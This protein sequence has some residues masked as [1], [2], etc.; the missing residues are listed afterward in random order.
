MRKKIEE[1]LNAQKIE[2]DELNRLIRNYGKDGD[3]RKTKRYL[4]D[5]LKTFS[6][7]FNVIGG[8]NQKIIPLYDHS[9]HANQPYFKEKT[10]A[11]IKGSYEAAKTD[12]LERLKVLDEEEV[13]ASEQSLNLIDDDNGKSPSATTTAQT[14]DDSTATTSSNETADKTNGGAQIEDS[15]L[16]MSFAQEIASSGTDMLDIQYNDL[17]ELIAGANDINENS[18][19]GQVTTY[20]QMLND[21]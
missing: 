12:I 4:E 20:V 6:E 10:F 15:P 11:K 14:I 5:K 3:E 2:V 9:K 18:S 13:S 1:L 8:N 7:A 19:R 17:M 16:D 21:T